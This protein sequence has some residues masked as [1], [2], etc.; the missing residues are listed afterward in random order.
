M[1]FLDRFKGLFVTGTRE[2][3]AEVIAKNAL[4]LIEAGNAIEDENRLEE[5][6]AHYQNAVNMAPHL[7][8]AHLNV[9]NIRLKLGHIG[10]ALESYDAAI[11]A[12]AAYA[13]G[14]YNMGNA[15]LRAHHPHAALKA[16]DK[17]IEL[18]PEFVDAHLARAD[19]LGTFFRDREAAR[20]AY[21]RVFE[22]APDYPDAHFSESLYLLGM[23]E[24]EAG[25]K[26]HEWRW[27]S[28]NYAASPRFAQPLWLGKE[29]LEDKTIF[30]H[31][32][33]GLGDTIQFCRYAK[34]VA[35]R[36]ARVLLGVAPPL[37]SLLSKLEGVS[38]VVN[39]GALP[40]F[41]LHCPLMSLP[42]AFD[43]RLETI[44]APNAYI[45]ADPVAVA[46]WRNRL[47]ATS[48]P[49]I[50]IVWSGNPNQAN[51]HNRSIAL[52][53]FIKTISDRAQFVSLQKDLRPSDR[54]EM[55]A[56][57]QIVQPADQLI[58]FASTA[59]LIANL[60]LIVSVDTSVAHLAGAMGKPLWVLLAFT[61][62]WR[63]F[64]ERSDCPWYP[65]ARLFRQDETGD[66]GKVISTISG[67]MALWQ[68]NWEHCVRDQ[69]LGFFPA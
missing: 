25:W 12:D 48:K 18:K 9:G 41:D 13:A 66:W 47:G 19:I 30:L 50:G 20:I 14:Y 51:D 15:H 57:P 65:S 29:P 60:D 56:H 3:D 61:A 1:R 43:T 32:E 44:P 45:S 11:A 2:T 27:Q 39:D 37:R 36:G 42:H 28:R 21:R 4:A 54:A 17:A 49:R 24:F 69:Y 62:D 26:K 22:L 35:E 38:Q 10:S 58:D 68:T 55:D 53:T 6:L 7:A 63:W 31:A 59:A 40:A 8:R 67:E 16:Y 33:Q 64:N 34:L 46:T 5:A 52:S 23:G